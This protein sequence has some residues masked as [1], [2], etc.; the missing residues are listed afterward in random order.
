MS[1][2]RPSPS[3]SSRPSISP[4]RRA[5]RHAAAAR[6]RRAGNLGRPSRRR[7]RRNRRQAR[8]RNR[9]GPLPRARPEHPHADRHDRRAAAFEHG[10]RRAR[11][12]LRLAPPRAHRAGRRGAHRLLDDGAP[13][14]AKRCSTSSTSIATPRPSTRATTLAWTQAQVQLHHLGID[15]R[16]R[17][18]CS[19]VWPAT[20]ST[21]IRPCGRRPTRSCAA[22]AAQSG[23]WA[24]GHF[25]RSADRAAAHRRRRRSRH[26]A[27]V[28]AGARIL[29]D[30]AAGRRSRDPQ[31]ARSPPMSRTFRSRSKRW[32]APA[33]SRPQARGEDSAGGVFVLR[34]DLIPPETRA[35]LAVGRAGR[36][37]GAARQPVRSAR[38]RSSSA[39]VAKPP[40]ARWRSA[41]GAPDRR[42][43]RPPR[44][45][46]NSS[47]GS[48]ASPRT[49]GNM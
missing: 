28:A 43:R 15:C 47:T 9:P 25:R 4:S 40:P 21:P 45:S 23:L 18:A 34:A 5:P 17:P 19:S 26:R 10:R 39:S 7:R 48:A 42:R 13:R 41:A 31:R 2:I 29:A 35:L 27:P 6:A 38:P 24:L 22:P 3:C 44:R 20:C 46:S 11:P 14:R 8:D 1:R 30:E 37:G 16:A 36:A 12:D 32:S 49:A 33:R